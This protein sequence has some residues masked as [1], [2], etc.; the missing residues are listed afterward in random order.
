MKEDFKRRIGE[1]RVMKCGE[2]CTIIAYR[3]N[4]DIDVQFDD[5]TVIKNKSYQR[6]NQ[7]AI[8]KQTLNKTKRIGNSR[9]MN[10]GKRCTIIAYRN[11]GDIDVQFENGKIIS[12]RTYE[13]FLK[14]SIS[15]LEKRKT[16]DLIQKHINKKNRYDILRDSRINEKRLMKCGMMCTIID[17]RNA[18]DLDVLFEDG[19]VVNNKTYNWF[20]QGSIKHPELPHM[21]GESSYFHNFE[22]KLIS[23]ADG[24]TYYRAKCKQ[25]SLDDIMTPQQILE[26]ERIAHS[27]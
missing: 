13:H 4:R 17:Y 18:R 12:H 19:A 5:G 24:T 27:K 3:G 9:I 2:K 14:G 21:P 22:V 23:Y 26:H 20:S 6:F 15:Y 7:G 25:C 8:G 11:S 1:T 10:C 16:E